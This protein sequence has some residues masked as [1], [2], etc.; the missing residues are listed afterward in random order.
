VQKLSK[1]LHTYPPRAA[2]KCVKSV[3][4]SD[5]LMIAC[6]KPPSV[7]LHESHSRLFAMSNQEMSHSADRKHQLSS[8]AWPAQ[9]RQRPTDWPSR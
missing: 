4:P 5:T 2:Y 9:P 8:A 7:S 1:E 6:C 3:K